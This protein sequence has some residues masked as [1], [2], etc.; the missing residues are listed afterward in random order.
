MQSAGVLQGV[1]TTKSSNTTPAMLACIPTPP[2][3]GIACALESWTSSL[4]TPLTVTETETGPAPRTVKVN[5]VHQ[6]RLGIPL[7]ADP[8]TVATPPRQRRICTAPVE[9][10]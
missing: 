10:R 4:S 6:P 5:G 3:T 2:A 8:I 7:G 9:I 1:V